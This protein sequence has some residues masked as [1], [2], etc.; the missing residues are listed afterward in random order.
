MAY[1]TGVPTDIEDLI[2]DLFTFLTGATATWVQDEYDVSGNY[3]TIH[4]NSCYVSFRWDTSPATD[5][6]VYQSTGWSASNLPHE[7]PG[8]SGNGDTS[9]PINAER[10]VN[11]LGA[12]P[13]TAYYFFASDSAPFYC[14]VVVE[15][16]SGRFRHFGFGE[17]NKVGD[18]TGGEY[19][20]GHYWSQSGPQIDQVGGTQHS[21][22]FDGI[23]NINANGGTMRIEDFPGQGASDIWGVF[24]N[25]TSAGVDTATNDRVP[26]V[27]GSRDGFW[28]YPMGWIPMARLNAYKPFIPI[29][30]MWKDTTTAPDTWY[31]LGYQPDCVIVNMRYFNDGDIIT[32]GSDSWMVFS[33][34][35]KQYLQVNTEESWNGG[36]AY[37]RIT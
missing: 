14:H 16:T 2:G 7:Q 18:W 27:G 26:L 8:D 20:Y 15:M 21:L 12:G 34:V 31:L 22:V 11:L 4:K 17:I 32:V 5:L 1:Q 19:C 6:G 10:R 24:V 35:R 28:G 23:L 3:G 36:L 37:K 13:Y 9:T 33:W 25:S 30:A 29:P